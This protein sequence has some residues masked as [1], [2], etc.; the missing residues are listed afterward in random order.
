[1]L[2]ICRN[3]GVEMGF[4]TDLMGELNDAQSREFIIRSQVLPPVE[5]LKSA[6]SVNAKILQQEG[7]LGV[8]ADG[9]FADILVV[10]GNPLQD[11]Q[12]LQDQGAHLSVI[13][14]NGTFHKN[15]ISFEH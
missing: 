10:D 14:K 5:I 15:N 6:T 8:I 11:L 1:M 3:A 9:A 4:G 7:K 13:M 2:E 12:L